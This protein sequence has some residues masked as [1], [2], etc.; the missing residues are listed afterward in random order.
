MADSSQVA[1]ERQLFS[2][3]G[4]TPAEYSSGEHTRRGSL[5]KQSNTQVRSSLIEGAWR[6]IAADH[7]WASFFARVKARR[8]RQRAIVGVARRLIGRI[9]AAFRHPVLYHIEAVATEAVGIAA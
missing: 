6:A 3:T 4:L 9:R 7:S 1:N 8:G 2:Y 5:T